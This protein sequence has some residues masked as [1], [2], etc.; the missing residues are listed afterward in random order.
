MSTPPV[1]PP[2]SQAVQGGGVVLVVDDETRILSAV[3]RS[4][5]REGYEILTAETPVEALAILE[6]RSVD[7]ILS[8]HKMPGMNGLEFLALAALRRPEAARLLITGWTA[9]VPA[10]DLTALGIRALLAKPW[11]DAELK[12]AVRSA[13][14]R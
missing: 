4:L 5:R 1:A 13:L 9:E 8:D 7:V 2:D 11:D 12:A 10:R 14:T 3:R 6:A